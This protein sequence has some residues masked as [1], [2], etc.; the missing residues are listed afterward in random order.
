VRHPFYLANLVGA[1][2]TF[3]IA[4]LLG[5]VV[6]AAW[7]LAAVPVYA[8]TIRA[9]EA[10]L[11]R[12]FPERWHAYASR[13]GA[14]VPGRPA[15]SSPEVRVTWANLRAEREIPRC[16]RFLASA[17][18]VLG[19]TLPSPAGPVLVALAALGFGASYAVR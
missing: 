1:V 15:A 13:V 8:V 2:G 9:E 19:L 17:A 12:L 5:A 10:R 16:L 14:L 18:L 4:G 3:L 7:L 6:G 11:A